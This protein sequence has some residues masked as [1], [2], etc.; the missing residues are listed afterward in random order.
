[1]KLIFCFFTLTKDFF[2]YEIFVPA[3]TSS[4]TFSVSDPDPIFSKIRLVSSSRNPKNADR[5]SRSIRSRSAS[6]SRI[7]LRTPS[8]IWT[9][10][11][12][13][14][15]ATNASVDGFS[16]NFSVGAFAFSWDQCFKTFLAVTEGCE[17]V[18]A[19]KMPRLGFVFSVYSGL[20]F[21]RSVVKFSH[22]FTSQQTNRPG[23]KCVSYEC[24]WIH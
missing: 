7:K 10:P 2:F 22:V 15:F 9:W 23:S 19:I 16:S 17:I 18:V 6:A 20:M 21:Y 13:A 11:T 14:S 8:S 3:S 24:L 5:K 1:M 12:W 4:K